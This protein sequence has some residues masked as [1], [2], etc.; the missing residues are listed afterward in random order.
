MQPLTQ[1]KKERKKKIREIKRL[2]HSPYPSFCCKK[3]SILEARQRL[4]K[5]TEVV[6]RIFSLRGHGKLLFADI[7]DETGKIQLMFKYNLLGKKAFSLLKLFDVGDFISCQGKVTKSLR[8]EISILVE[9]FKLLAK[10]IRPLPE[11]W[12]GL[13]DIEERYRQR[14]VDILINPKVKEVLLFRTKLIHLLRQ[15]LN[16]HKFI[17]IETPILQPIYGGATAKPF[18]THHNALGVDLYLRISNEL[19]LKRLIVG[20]FEKVYEIG[21]DFRNE[22]I[23]KAHNPEFTQ[24]ELYWAYT[25]YHYLMEFTQDMFSFLL[26]NLKGGLKIKYK[27]KTYDFTPPWQRISYNQ[28]FQRFLGIDLAQVR[29]EDKLVQL[30]KKNKLLEEEKLIGYGNILD[31]VYKKH[32]RPKIKGPLFITDHPIELKP[33]AK[34][35]ENDPTKAASFQLVIEGE[36]FINAYNE[37]NDPIE[38]EKRWL[39]EMKLAKRGAE[40]YQVLDKDYIRALEY[41]M[42]PTAGWGLGIDRLVAFLTDQDNIKETIPF[43]TLKPEQ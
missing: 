42:P 12:H 35:K 37:L 39:K 31:K 38:Q 19:Y 11:K 30:I 5:K 14:Y 17:E 8:G 40:E 27:N 33:L 36:E 21:K 43:P 15:F 13:K 9:K 2:N 32:I 1:I 10:S 29:T 26:K 23:S 7:K 3:I 18:I 22:G 41:G 4:D 6:G 34:R 28:L 16:H 24:I 20:G 25:D